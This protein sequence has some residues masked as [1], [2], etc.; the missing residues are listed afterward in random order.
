MKKNKNNKKLE[1][2]KFEFNL[3]PETEKKNE[4]L[5][6]AAFAEATDKKQILFNFIN[7]IC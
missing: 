3:S 4:F 2:Q 6:R 5:L 1:T 7:N